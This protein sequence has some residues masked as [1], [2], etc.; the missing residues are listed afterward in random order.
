M[1][2][3][4]LFVFGLL[5]LLLAGCACEPAPVEQLSNLLV[6]H[7]RTPAS[8]GSAMGACSGSATAVAS[9]ELLLTR[10]QLQEQFDWAEVD[11]HSVLLRVL[12]KGEG[13]GLEDD[14]ALVQISRSFPSPTVPLRFDPGRQLRPGD[15]IYVL[16]YWTGKHDRDEAQQ[17]ES[18]PSLP[19][20]ILKAKV[21]RPPK[22][23]RNDPVYVPPEFICCETGSSDAL[24]GMSG[25]A[26]VVWDAEDQK[27]VYVDT[28]AR[29]WVHTTDDGRL[30][31]SVM[32][33]RR[34]PAE[35]YDTLVRTG[36]V[37]RW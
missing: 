8:N 34:L 26:A 7:I 28:Y 21:V 4:I 18:P 2:Y 29:R 16:G 31:R 1:R 3:R 6:C 10:H 12:A 23:P 35:V 20:T 17:S 13:E 33:V 30:K 25:G 9:N 11:G 5:N 37:L 19:L 15:C 27:W 24:S 14:W 22:P 32:L 36:A